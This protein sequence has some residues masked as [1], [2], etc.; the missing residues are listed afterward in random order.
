VCPL[1]SHSEKETK[2]H[3][4]VARKYMK[5]Q[6]LFVNKTTHTLRTSFLF[7]KLIYFKK[8]ICK[9]NGGQDKT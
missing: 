7:K 3:L 1:L 9:N 6:F 8:Y 4:D 5:M 2:H